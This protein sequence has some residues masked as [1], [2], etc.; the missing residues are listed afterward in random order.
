M[1]AAA[2]L[3]M[4]LSGCRANPPGKTETAVM[5]WA[6]HKMF[7]HNKAQ[8]NPL[9]DD[10]AGIA[11]GKEAFTHYCVA[12]HGLDGQNT[13]VPFA[14]RMAP[15][16]P[17]LAGSDVQAYTD[18][19]LKWIIDYGIWPS[20]MPGSK[21]IL[22]DD[23]IWSI[24]VYLRHLPKAGSLGEPDMYTHCIPTD[25]MPL[26]NSNSSSRSLTRT[27]QLRE[28]VLLTFCDPLPA[29]L[30][31][32]QHLS[33]RDWKELLHWLD[34]SGL[35][36]YFLD[37][38]REL[39]LAWSLPQS[40]H[41]R[42]NQ[43]LADNWERL[44]A[45]IS[46][47]AM[48]Q[49]RFQLA[50]VSY[51]VL[52]GFSLWPI[53]VPHPELRSQLDLDFLV[54]E[55]S[56]SEARRILEESGYRLKAISGK[57]WEFKSNE[58]QPSSLKTLYQAGR[59]GAVELHLEA[60][61][62]GPASLLSR[63]E[64]LSF[65]GVSMPVLAP[66]DLFLGQGLHLYK[67][68]C[69]EFVRTAHLIEFRR[70]V[71][72]RFRD[73]AFWHQL[74]AQTAGDPGISMKLGAVIL[75]IS[76]V[77]GPFAPDALTRWTVDN[78][79]ANAGRWADLYGHRIALASFPGCKLYLL[80]QA[81]LEAAGLPAKRPLLQVL[82]PRRL[83]PPIAHAPADEGVF[84]RVNRYRKQLQ[85]ILFRLRFHTVEGIRFLCESTFWRQYR[86]QFVQ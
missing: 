14:D 23:E 65:Q 36:L 9:K 83:P 8:K 84:A 79:P 68:V 26:F 80:L 29:E 56:A 81:E 46:E 18:G 37:R 64:K 70:H 25:S 34:T 59:S 10:A 13:G 55:A 77:M 15:P 27:Q 67:H 52:K 71:I 33:P 49:R 4:M 16:V 2:M 66:V 72:A 35:A 74:Q 60:A 32:L 69:S 24:V 82:L 3:A 50:G 17:S 53:S 73:H 62:S 38:M 40:I 61:A 85:F 63:A 76:R 86:N 43:N 39:N 47:S 57:S 41:R 42:L 6:K 30:A 11:G 1:L 45:M 7:V 31:R 54:A 28:A 48:I 44:D 51:A 5:S 75:L 19:Q 58:H 20:G 22:S 21:N 78:L 12:C